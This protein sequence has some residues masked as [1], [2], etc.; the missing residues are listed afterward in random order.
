[1][2]KLIIYCDFDGTIT[3]LDTWMAVGNYFIREKETWYEIIRKF[4]NLEIGAREC[5]LKECDLIEN[6]DLEIFNRIIENQQLDEY[7][8]EFKQFCEQNNLPITIMSEGM[9]YYIQRI[10]KKYNFELPYYANKFVLS[11]D[12]KSFH[13]EFPFSDAECTKCGCCKR[14][15]LM[16]MTADDEISVYIGDGYSDAC[17][18]HYADI[19]FAKKSLA[20]YCWKN[21]IT[22]FEYKNFSDIKSKLEKII[23]K[24]NIKHR[25]TASLKRKEVFLRG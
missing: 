18:T 15:L 6:F 5:F 11:K 2:S 1:M 4:E 8:L 17:V 12:E 13:L 19:V 9:D 16:N 25:Q 22:Y 7:F 24:K 23:S 14:N 3:T 20:S 10:L 21:N